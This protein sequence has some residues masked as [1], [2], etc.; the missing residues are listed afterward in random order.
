M[1]GV[2]RNGQELLLADEPEDFAEA[3]LNLLANRGLWSK[4]GAAGQA[5]ARA[6]Y[7]WDTLVPQ[8]ET[9]YRDLRQ[10]ANRQ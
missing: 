5:F 4:L 6:N 10:T 3:V 1:Y 8:L 9:I 2:R 7:G